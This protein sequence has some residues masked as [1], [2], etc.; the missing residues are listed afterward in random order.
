MDAVLAEIDAEITAAEQGL[1]E[2][3]LQRL[4]A[5]ALL[6][7]LRR[8]SPPSAGIT[9]ATSVHTGNKDFIAALLAPHESGLNI[10]DIEA[11]AAERGRELNSEQVRSA[12]TYLKRRGKAERVARGV[13]RLVDLDAADGPRDTSAPSVDAEGAED[14]V[15]EQGEGGEYL[16]PAQDAHDPNHSSSEWDRDRRGDPA[17]AR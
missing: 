9:P 8:N 14:R 5:E 13:W 15:T 17:I 1:D 3:R 11:K 4:G 10:R 16:V 6:A 12:L 7:R 2:L